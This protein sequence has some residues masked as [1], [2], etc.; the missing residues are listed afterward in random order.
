MH[1]RIRCPLDLF[2]SFVFGVD[3]IFQYELVTN[4]H[5]TWPS[6]ARFTIEKLGTVNKDQIW[7]SPLRQKRQVTE[8]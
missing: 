3:M 4:R 5:S 7:V 6:L 2:F 8:R 1:E